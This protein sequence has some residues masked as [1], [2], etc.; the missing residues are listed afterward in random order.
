MSTRLTIVSDN[1]AADGLK[2]EHGF[3]GWIE[4]LDHRIL[5][6]TGEG[7]AFWYNLDALAIDIASATAVALSHG[8]YDH[9]G[10]LGDVLEKASTAQLYCHPGCNCSRY[11]IRERAKPI[12]M[13]V[14]SAV[15]MAAMRVKNRRAVT[16][17]TTIAP[18]VKLSGP[19]PRVTDFEDCGGPFFLDKEA[20]NPDPVLDDN[21][22]W[23][24][25]PQGLVICLGCSHAGLINTLTYITEI[26]KQPRIALVVG[27]AH[28]GSASTER[29]EKTV[30][31]LANLQI[32]RMVFC[33]CSGDTATAYLSE[34][35]GSY[36]S[37]GYAGFTADF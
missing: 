6:D 11:S 30:A 17:P 18:G 14:D 36:V 35:L 8:H 37:S 10:N 3:A 9:T 23:F 13:P 24:D 26:S 2:T 22:L 29:L 32:S 27:G 1:H 21:A 31:A 15:T 5:F 7:D 33:H 28:L 34:K 16:R 20:A 12:G 4:H 25:T 19:I